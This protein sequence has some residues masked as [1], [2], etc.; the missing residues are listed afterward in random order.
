MSGA[1]AVGVQ[2]FGAG[3]GKQ[4]TLSRFPPRGLRVKNSSSVDCCIVS[5]ET[6]SHLR[7][8]GSKCGD[9]AR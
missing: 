2:I 7:E 3:D 5:L 4:E 8:T 1:C 6:G 9:G